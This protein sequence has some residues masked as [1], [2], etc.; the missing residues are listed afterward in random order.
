LT[1]SAKKHDV[2]L[3]NIERNNWK[4][5]GNNCPYR[6]SIKEEAKSNNIFVALHEHHEHSFSVN[7]PACSG[8]G[9][10]RQYDITGVTH[11]CVTH[12][13]VVFGKILKNFQKM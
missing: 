5:F 8:T 6:W 1:L 2:K 7:R 12:N 4:H 13:C 3:I 11:N 9:V 10:E